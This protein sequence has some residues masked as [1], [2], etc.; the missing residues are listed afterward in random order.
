VFVEELKRKC[1]A[2]IASE[3]SSPPDLESVLRGALRDNPS[4]TQKA[5]EKIARECGAVEERD[6]IR[7]LLEQLTGLRK[8]GPKAGEKSRRAISVIR[9]LH[10]STAE[11]LALNGKPS[12]SGE[13]LWKP[14]QSPRPRATA[15]RSMFC[16]ASKQAPKQ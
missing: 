4:L 16:G 1:A 3:D 7:D 13:G 14:L 10:I 9:R 11:L 5:A 15:I 8:P 12:H 6:T 2:M